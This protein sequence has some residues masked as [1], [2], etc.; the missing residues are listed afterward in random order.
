MDVGA[1]LLVALIEEGDT[2]HFRKL[3]LTEKLFFGGEK[4]LYEFINNHVQEYNTLP[5]METVAEQFSDIP[6]PVEP[7]GY[8]MDQVENRFSHKRLGRALTECTDLMKM[9]DSWSAQ[10]LLREAL[11]D[12][13]S[14][15]ARTSMAEFSAD[16][17]ELYMAQYMKIQ[18]GGENP[19]ILSGWPTLDKFGGLR[20]GDIKSIVGRPAMGK[21]FTIL[22]EA[23]HVMQVQQRSAM[24][25]SMEMS[26]QEI[27]ERL[28]AMYTKFPMA[29]VQSYG[30]TTT[31]QKK[32]PGLLLKSKDEKAKLWVLDGNF[33]STVGDI[34]SIAYQLSPAVVYIDGAYLLQHEDKRLDRYRRVEVN[35]EL[36]KKASGELK[37][38]SVLSYQFNREAA[39]K[40]SKHKEI[41]GLESIA[42][43]DAIGQLSSVVLG[44]FE[45][46]NVETLVAR[47]INILKGRKGQTGMFRINWNFQTMD[48]SEIDDDEKKKKGIMTFL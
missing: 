36:I 28:V 42:F 37:I 44:M 9:Q 18:E 26:L 33:A 4:D 1:K 5:K 41:P 27:M 23:M 12:I 31:Q 39:K 15:M 2:I 7:I 14:T 3:S 35:A 34:Y 19:E 32:F 16:A 10:N 40:Q 25:V 20:A 38:P 22:K 45:S 29:H 48:F 43:S 8:Y 11:A 13:Q 17:Y 21:T 47:Q 6:K 24:V 46:D 30:F